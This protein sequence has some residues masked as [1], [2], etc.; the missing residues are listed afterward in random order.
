MP[1]P[2]FSIATLNCA[3]KLSMGDCLV[4]APRMEPGFVPISRKI[5]LKSGR[6]FVA[7][8]ALTADTGSPYGCRRR[9]RESHKNLLPYRERRHVVK[10][11]RETNDAKQSVGP[12]RPRCGNR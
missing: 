5:R 10:D 3:R 8:T 11:G 6:G 4:Q 7:S 9:S 1:Q 12:I 2:Q